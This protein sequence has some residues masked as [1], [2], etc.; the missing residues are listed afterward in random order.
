MATSAAVSMRA[1]LRVVERERRRLLEFVGAEIK[2]EGVRMLRRGEVEAPDELEG[3]LNVARLVA[4]ITDP[5]HLL[6]VEI[7]GEDAVEVIESFRVERLGGRFVRW[8]RDRRHRVAKSG[9]LARR[10]LAAQERAAKQRARLQDL[11]IALEEKKSAGRGVRAARGRVTRQRARLREAARK[12]VA[13]KLSARRRPR[14]RKG[15]SD[16]LLSRVGTL[17][18]ARRF[19]TDVRA[20]PFGARGA[21]DAAEL[22]AR[23]VE[24]YVER[25]RSG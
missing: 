14:L 4:K 24:R 18:Q 1:V 16:V 9:A 11:E 7:Q 25:E 15:V 20:W 5:R 23:A 21:E 17:L 3:A 8:L 12:V 22:A 6:R 13:A 10:V 19:R 2:A